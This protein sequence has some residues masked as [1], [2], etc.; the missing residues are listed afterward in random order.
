ML[1]HIDVNPA[2]CSEV[3][4]QI[5]VRRLASLSREQMHVEYLDLGPDRFLPHLL[6]LFIH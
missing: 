6:Q 2:A 3:P 5:S 1:G 4:I